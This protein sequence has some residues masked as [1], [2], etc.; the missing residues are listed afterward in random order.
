[1][2][3]IKINSYTERSDS[4]ARPKICNQTNATIVA[5]TNNNKKKLS[6]LTNV[7]DVYTVYIQYTKHL[8]QYTSDASL[9]A[10]IIKMSPYS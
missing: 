9:A 10:N 1:M 8:P 3:K 5:N 6:D 4:I 7:H 2:Y